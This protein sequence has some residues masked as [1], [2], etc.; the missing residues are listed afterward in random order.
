MRDVKTRRRKV[1]AVPYMDHNGNLAKWVLTCHKDESV[2][3]IIYVGKE[4]SVELISPRYLSVEQ[5]RCF[6]A[7]AMHVYTNKMLDG[8]E[9][10]E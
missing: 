2:Q 7:M 10:G 1:K 8:P 6:T 5:F 4:P 3:V 9:S